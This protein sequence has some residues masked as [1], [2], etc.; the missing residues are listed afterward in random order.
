MNLSEF[1]ERVYQASAAD[2]PIISDDPIATEHPHLDALI[3]EIGI[4]EYRRLMDLW[5]DFPCK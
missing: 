2:Q 1:K 3:A 4:D 5:E